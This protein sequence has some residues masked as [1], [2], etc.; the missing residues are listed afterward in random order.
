MNLYLILFLILAICV[1]IGWFYP[2]YEEKLYIF[3]W[4]LMTAILCLRFGQGT[5]YVT[6]HAIYEMIPVAIDLSQG[7]ICGLYPEIGW[8]LLCAFFKLLHAP[9]W[10]FTAV[11]GLAEMLLLHRFLKKYVPMKTA[12][13][14]LSY[15]VLFLVYMVSGLRQGLAMCLFLGLALP[16]YMEKKWIKYIISVFLLMS[17]HKVGFVWLLLVVVYYL[18]WQSCLFGVGLSIIVGMLL[19]IEAVAYFILEVVPIYQYHL[20]QFLLSGEISIFA[21]GERLISFL[22]LFVLYY[23]YQKKGSL[24][25]QTELFMKA[26]SCGVFFYMI[27]MA[28]SYYASRY[29]IGFKILEAV[30]AVFFV[31]KEEK[32]A[33]LAALFFFCLTLLMGV[34]NLNAMVF[35]GGYSNAGVK[36]WNYPYVSIFQPEK[37]NQYFNYEKRFKKMYK[38]TV[39]DQELWRIEE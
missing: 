13:L 15:P 27:F 12:G 29:A 1:L 4:I 21:I 14:F 26:Y 19:Q 18:P 23:Y 20:G 34:K 33:K 36:L 2:R 30:L 24:D 10:V 5:D 25:K 37:I 35:E 38:Y 7:Y 6:Y 11:L 9:F 28:N 32:I 39:E 22:V 8:R 16:Y 31:R 3:C 17:F